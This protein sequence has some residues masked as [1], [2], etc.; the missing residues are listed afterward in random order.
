M[1]GL[2]PFQPL[3]HLLVYMLGLPHP[4]HHE[5]VVRG[6]ELKHSLALCGEG[7]IERSHF[8][9]QDGIAGLFLLSVAKKLSMQ[10]VASKALPMACPRP[11]VNT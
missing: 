2:L 8:V 10:N 11:D 5:A 3:R 6:V 9:A 4:S 1:V 7:L